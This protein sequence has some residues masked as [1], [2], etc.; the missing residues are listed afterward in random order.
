MKAL[1]T[2]ICGFSGCYLAEY[3]IQQKVNVHGMDIASQFPARWSHLKDKITFHQADIRDKKKAEKVITKIKPDYIFHLAALLRGD[4]FENLF[5]VNVVGTRNILD[6]ALKTK[7]RVLISGSA[8]E[9]GTVSRKDL[10]ISEK[11]PLNPISYYGLSKVAQTMLGVHYS[12]DKKAKVYLARVF[13]MTGPGEPENMVCSSFAWQIRNSKTIYVGNLSPKRDFIDVRDV[14][15]AYWNVINKG[16][17]GEIYNICSGNPYSIKEAFA[18]LIK[19]SKV[20]GVVI[21][22]SKDRIRKV[23]IPIHVGDNLKIRKDT[24]WSPKISFDQTLKD[25][26]QNLE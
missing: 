22:Q 19:I 6:A 24:G 2:G 5:D 16:K 20:K 11:A 7:S 21:K 9:Y 1:I 3:L 8:A 4:K 23:D 25:I 14:V 13:N 15:A 18:K 10:P 26:F 12:K 17:A